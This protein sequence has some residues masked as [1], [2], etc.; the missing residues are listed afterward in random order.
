MWGRAGCVASRAAGT[1]LQA[2]LLFLSCLSLPSCPGP[3]LEKDPGLAS[4]PWPPVLWTRAESQA[5]WIAASAKGILAPRS[6]P[7]WTVNLG[8]WSSS[9]GHGHLPHLLH[10]KKLSLPSV[11]PSGT[12][13]HVRSCHRC[14]V[15]C[16]VDQSLCDGR[17]RAWD[18]SLSCHMYQRFFLSLSQSEL[19]P[20]DLAVFTPVWGTLLGLCASQ[21]WRSHTQP[22]LWGLTLLALAVASPV[23]CPPG[24]HPQRVVGDGHLGDGL[25]PGSQA[26]PA[27]CGSEAGTHI[28]SGLLEALSWAASQ[29]WNFQ[30]QEWGDWKVAPAA[31][32]MSV[33]CSAMCPGPRRRAQG[34]GS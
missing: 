33:E 2:R 28:S 23:S 27:P 17:G 12:G 14:L 8:V 11:H 25:T 24:S 13:A 26:G 4:L 1:H 34:R 15:L 10:L 6:V 31:G 18:R 9:H 29:N 19:F 22:R 21:P 16:F 32:Q 30:Q 20:R 3:L 7:V 5:T